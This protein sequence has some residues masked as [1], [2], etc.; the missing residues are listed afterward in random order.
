[1]LAAADPYD[2]DERARGLALLSDADFGG[3]EPYLR[4]YRFHTLDS[5][6]TVRAVAILS[7]GRH[8]A[9][10]DL[11]LF[12]QALRDPSPLVRWEAARAMRRFHDPRRASIDQ[13]IK[14]A[15]APYDPGR[16][17]PQEQVEPGEE[18]ADVRT[19]A[20]LA[21]GQYPEP[22]VFDALLAALSDRDFAVVHAA[23]RSLG[24]L[25]GQDLGTDPLAW[26]AWRDR[27][28][29][30]LFAGRRPYTWEGYPAQ[31]AW[32]EHILF[33]QSRPSPEHPARTLSPASTPAEG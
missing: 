4:L 2:P 17:V 13:L 15:R 1:V 10:A 32:Y 18:D 14:S 25:T 19:A 23:Q 31:T 28:E 24:L 9:Q 26:S 20:A 16:G 29:N 11:D 22:G 33:W 12:V 5:D 7:L 30:K 27:H 8:G 3:E 6:A 21:L